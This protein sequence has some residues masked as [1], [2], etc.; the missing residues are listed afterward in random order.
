MKKT[1]LAKALSITEKKWV[2]ITKE[3]TDL[4]F[5]HLCGRVTIPQIQRTKGSPKGNSIYSYMLRAL[6][7]GVRR[8][9]IYKRDIANPITKH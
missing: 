9:D 2:K 5:A 4:V 6:R 3:D 7:E 1:L 8:G